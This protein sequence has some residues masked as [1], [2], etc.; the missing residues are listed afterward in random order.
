MLLLSSLLGPAKPPVASREDVASASGTYCIRR[1]ADI[2]IAEATRGMSQI[3]IGPSERCLVCLEEYQAEEEVRQL[4]K[5]SHLFHRDCIDVV[6]LMLRPKTARLTLIFFGPSGSLL[7]VILALCAEAKGL[8]RQRRLSKSA[9]CPRRCSLR[10][11]ESLGIVQLPNSTCPA[12]RLL[13]NGV[14]NTFLQTP[15]PRN[16]FVM[17][18]RLR[19]SSTA[20][21]FLMRQDCI[22]QGVIIGMFGA[23]ARRYGGFF[24]CIISY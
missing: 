5:C 6:C 15:C 10:H 3:R 4:K 24:V 9:Q 16:E 21:Y 11:L 17:L 18:E 1:S 12:S 19:L 14:V 8:T 13:E 20:T 23:V 2:L 7:G 22:A